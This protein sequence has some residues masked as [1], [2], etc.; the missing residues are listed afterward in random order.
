MRVSSQIN[1][2]NTELK[3][4]K[5]I[6]EAPLVA[7]KLVPDRNSTNAYVVFKDQSAAAASMELNMREVDGRH[8]R[9]DRAAAPSAHANEAT[10]VGAF[11]TFFY[12]SSSSGD[13]A[14]TT[15]A[16]A[17]PR[18]TR[19]LD[20]FTTGPMHLDPSFVDENAFKVNGE[21]SCD[22]ECQRKSVN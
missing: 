11:T 10:A 5:N 21:S 9:V 8:V 18:A 19:C 6:R 2:L 3:S 4:E 1:V 12:C 15:R 13:E 22:E 14:L 17:S 20:A 7:G 16:F